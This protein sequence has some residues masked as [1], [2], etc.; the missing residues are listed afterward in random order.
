MSENRSVERLLDLLAP[1]AAASAAFRKAAKA[2]L[3]KEHPDLAWPRGQAE[4][5]LFAGLL[6][7]LMRPLTRAAQDDRKLAATL[8]EALQRN[9]PPAKEKKSKTKSAA[10]PAK[11][12]R[13]RLPAKL[14]PIRLI[15]KGEDALR[16][17]LAG[18]DLDELRDVVVGHAMDAKGN[19]RK[20]KAADKLIGHIVEEAKRRRDHGTSFL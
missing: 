19:V 2:A 4:K 14:D 13:G 7:A 3:I 6:A 1:S 18:L 8:A 16:R 10:K 9:L 20:W 12:S 5:D 11:K 17:A 15:Y